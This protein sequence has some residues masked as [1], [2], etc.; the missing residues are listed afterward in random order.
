MIR[1]RHSKPTRY[2]VSCL[3]TCVLL[4]GLG[5]NTSRVAT[6]PGKPR[7]ENLIRIALACKDVTAGVTF[8]IKVK[9]A[10]LAD[11]KITPATSAAITD[12]LTKVQNATL[13]LANRSA[14]FDTFT[15]GRADLFSLFTALQTARSNL[16]TNGTIP[17]FTGMAGEI[18][19]WI[20]VGFDALKPVFE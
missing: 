18:V 9:R 17:G 8:G 6:T 15:A 3:M 10:L 12:H 5:C 4:A 16:V 7:D 11:G 13:E 14:E 1:L 19:S 20:D 2:A